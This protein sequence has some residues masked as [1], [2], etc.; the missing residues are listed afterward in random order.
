MRNRIHLSH[1]PSLIT[2][3]T[4]QET[5]P[6]HPETA[7]AGSWNRIIL[8]MPQD[9][10][11]TREKRCAINTYSFGWMEAIQLSTKA[12]VPLQLEASR[13]K[14]HQ[15]LSFSSSEALSCYYQHCLGCSTR[16]GR[17]LDQI[18]GKINSGPLTKRKEN[19]VKTKVYT[20]LCHDSEIQWESIM[21]FNYIDKAKKMPLTGRNLAQYQLHE[22]P[23]D[24]QLGKGVEE[25][26]KNR[27]NV[28]INSI[29]Q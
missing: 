2:G 13:I 8:T 1:I 14:H 7:Q 28:T 22:P 23:A 27:C 29:L 9:G 26:G 18:R 25:V 12:A 17:G 10:I 24:V 6:T 5:S 4:L 11:P 21:P 20:V 16:E 19:H 15:L 3:Q